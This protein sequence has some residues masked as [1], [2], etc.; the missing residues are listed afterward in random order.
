[1]VQ[2]IPLVNN[3][4]EQV[5]GIISKS[6]AVLDLILHVKGVLEQINGT[7]NKIFAAVELITVASHVLG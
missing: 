5:N 3:V 2:A 1:V 7:R 6:S 4:L